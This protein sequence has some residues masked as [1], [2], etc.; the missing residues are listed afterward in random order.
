MLQHLC[1]AF[2]TLYKDGLITVH[3]NDNSTRNNSSF[4]MLHNLD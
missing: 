3:I 4:Q 1:Q 2:G